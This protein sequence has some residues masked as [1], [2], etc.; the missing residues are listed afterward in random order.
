MSA[1]LNEALGEIVHLASEAML[2]DDEQIKLQAIGD[3]GDIVKRN[4]GAK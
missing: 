3:I 4:G 1:K 2:I